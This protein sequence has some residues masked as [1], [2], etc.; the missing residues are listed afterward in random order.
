[1]GKKSYFNPVDLK[2]DFPAVEN[3]LLASWNKNG[4]VKKYLSRNKNSK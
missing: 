3:E 4:I 1:M 2:V